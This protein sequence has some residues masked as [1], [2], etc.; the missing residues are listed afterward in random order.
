MLED[1][2]NS[3]CGKK[4]KQSDEELPWVEQKCQN[5]K[6]NWVVDHQ[7]I[8]WCGLEGTLEII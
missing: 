3:F 4:K 1:F 2:F 8:E 7:I 5:H 6:K